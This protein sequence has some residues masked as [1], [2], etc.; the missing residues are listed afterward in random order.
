[1]P[2]D[3]IQWYP[4]HM[5]RTRRMLKEMLPLT[6]LVIEVSDARI[7]LSSSNPDLKKLTEGKKRLKIL[8]KTDLADPE[9]TARWRKYFVCQGEQAVFV[10]A[11]SGKGTGEI[12]NAVG[13]LMS[14]KIEKYQSKG[15]GGRRI[16]AII[17]GIPNAGKSS[18]INRLAGGKRAK[19]EDRPGVTREKQW[20]TT[21]A[22]LDLLDTPGMLWP[23]LEDQ[24][25]AENLALTGAIR[26]EILDAERFAVLLCGRLY[27]KYPSLLEARYKIQ[28]AEGMTDREIFEAAGRKRGCILPGNE[29]DAERTSVML[30][31]EFRGGKIGRITLEEPPC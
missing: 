20:I 28:L 24:T 10:D 9:S 1:M 12:K 7:P 13:Q 23:K 16:K 11:N 25:A 30:L 29:L 26:D 21:S 18:L 17:V 19:V 15:M 5:A 3:Q 22:G 14:E 8:T 6:D 31:D 27:A 2:S 4:G